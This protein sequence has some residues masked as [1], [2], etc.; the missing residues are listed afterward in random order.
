MKKIKKVLLL[1]MSLVMATGLFTGCFAGGTNNSGNGTSVETVDGKSAYQIWLDN[2]F[3][4][5]EED[6]LEWL[7]G[8]K[9]QDGEDGED[10]KS[11]YQIWLENGHSG[12][13]EDFFDWLKGKCDHPEDKES[14][15]QAPESSTQT[16]DSSVVEAEKF[17]FT[18]VTDKFAMDGTTSTE[19]EA[20][21][22]LEL[23]AA[24]EAEGK[25]FTGW[26]DI[27]G[28]KVEEG[29]T[30][31]EEDYAIFAT[32]EINAYTLTIKQDGADDVTLKFGVEAVP[33]TETAEEIIDINALDFVLGIMYEGTTEIAYEF[34][35]K[36]EAWALEDTTIT[37]V[38]TVAKY[39]FTVVTGNP[40]LDPNASVTTEVE[41]G[42]EVE[43][44]AAPEAEGKTFIGWVD[45]EG[46]AV[47]ENF[48]MP[49]ESVAIFA[50]WEINA[51]TLTIKQDG[52]E[53]VTLK[54]GVEAVPATETTD[55]I[56]DVNAL[57]FVLESFLP[58][59]TETIEY[60]YDA[61]PETWALADTTISIIETARKYTVT[62]INTLDRRGMPVTK[63]IANGE[64]IEY[65]TYEAVEGMNFAGWVVVDVETGLSSVA[66]T[67]MPTND[68]TVYTD[69]QVIVYTLTINRIDGTVDTYKFGVQDVYAED[70]AE[71]VI[72]I[73]Y[74]LDREL[75][76]SKSVPTASC[77]DIEYV[78]IPENG[79][80]L[81]DTTISEQKVDVEGGEHDFSVIE[82]DENGHWNACSGCGA[83]GEVV[84]HTS[85]F[86]TN[87]NGTH[88]EV[89]GECD[90]VLGNAV[91]CDAVWSEEITEDG[92]KQK[93]CACGYV[94]EEIDV[95]NETVFEINLDLNEAGATTARFSLFDLLDENIIAF[96][97]YGLIDM[98]WG[99]VMIFNFLAE[100]GNYGM[101]PMDMDASVFGTA[102]GLQTL[103]MGVMT[104]DDVKHVID[105]Q[106]SLV[107]SVI[108]TKEELMAFNTLSKLCEED[109]NTY[110]GYFKLG[111]N[112]T[113]NNPVQ[114]YK[115]GQTVWT[116]AFYGLDT[117]GFVGTFD[118]C[119]YAIDGMIVNASASETVSAFI[120]EI[121]EGGVLKNVAFTNA[122]ISGARSV[123]TAFNAG[124]V[125]NVYVHVFSF[126]GWMQKDTGLFTTYNSGWCTSATAIINGGGWDAPGT[127]KN[128]FVDMTESAKLNT[129]DAPENANYG[130]TWHDDPE[131]E[132]TEQGGTIKPLG[133]PSTKAVYEGVYVVG[134][135]ANLKVLVHNLQE[136]DLIARYV[137]FA[138]MKAAYDA[139]NSALAAEIATWPTWLRG[140]AIVNILDTVALTNRKAVNLDLQ[141]AGKVVTANAGFAEVDV[142]EIEN[143]G[144]LLAVTYNGTAISGCSLEGTTV[145]VPA[146]AFGFDFGEKTIEIATTT[147]KYSLPVLLVSKVIKTAADLDAMNHIAKAL[148]ADQFTFDGYFQLGNDIAYNGNYLPMM[149]FSLGV[150]I[151]YSDTVVSETTRDVDGYLMLNGRYVW[152]F[153]TWKLI[154]NPD[155]SK[156]TN[157]GG[158]LAYDGGNCYLTNATTFARSM[159]WSGT[160]FIGTFDGCGYTI[161]G[162]TVGDG[163]ATYASF[164]PVLA[165]TGVIKNVAFT[166]AKLNNTG[167]SS[168][169]LT[170]LGKEGSLIENVYVQLLEVKGNITG[171]IQVTDN[172]RSNTGSTIRNVLVDTTAVTS[173]SSTFYAVGGSAY[174][175]DGDGVI[176]PFGIYD[177]VYAIVNNETQQTKA[178]GAG[179]AYAGSVNY[180]AFVGAEAMKNDAAAQAE[181]A[182][183][184][185]TY[186]TIVEGVPTWNK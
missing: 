38:E 45:V 42:A 48:T 72:G 165:A 144:D 64:A 132:G 16:P 148:S 99:D 114:I 158:K 27:E 76:N 110:G 112:I 31:P 87:N 74:S 91:A 14:S 101:D 153:S 180:A 20:G 73:G 41:Y 109:A 15:T 37:V 177:G 142:S 163:K 102:Y 61:L 155:V 178:F 125:E 113:L 140:N 90:Y 44:P 160:G 141:A 60:A 35:G 83:K 106:V 169:F 93:V 66:P 173:T 54:F 171:A 152:S 150:A 151:A 80:A 71:A 22:V 21:A 111:A 69:W 88:N 103:S 167:T 2:G 96:E 119:G 168:G 65:P 23:P 175:K 137:D 130:K 79:I 50:A 32:W 39:S 19:V 55:E 62:F 179:G 34:E 122:V 28:N 70:P 182:T 47:T 185:T 154:Q 9:G 85:S 56:I 58:E 3:S 78:G 10:G 11:A 166:N 135:P 147:G 53:D 68:L 52:A 170:L 95:S 97:K 94:D 186:W 4:G 116:P 51:Y 138:A 105:V 36:P 89:C 149:D 183:W 126:G 59:A 29:A 121:G 123:I 146:A 108:E 176:D 139:E 67:V 75:A 181:I 1:A 17:V 86:V 133:K 107:T 81:E 92:M 13:E 118:G 26:V 82:G 100:D 161:D 40:R 136:S 162:M 128:L 30:M 77:Y 104:F 127:V 124:T 159:G 8:D 120:T 156:F 143:V 129:Q 115:G 63:E 134:L 131:V 184:D 164:I 172:T 145:F 84:A 157:N 49:A 43:L 117:N 174:D 33:A 46:N 18:V 24:P 57:N 7:K 6:F 5:T 12:T 98:Y 25:T